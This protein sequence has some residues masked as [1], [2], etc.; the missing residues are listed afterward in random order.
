MYGREYDIK[1]KSRGLDGIKGNE[2]IE[3]LFLIVSRTCLRE[4]N[5]LWNKMH[6]Q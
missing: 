6:M 1:Q 3:L 2:T 5:C 4:A